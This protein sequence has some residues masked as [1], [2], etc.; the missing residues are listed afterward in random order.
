MRFPC[1]L[2]EFQAQFPNEAK[3]WSDLRE[4]RWPHGF[5]CPRCARRGSHFLATR[6]LEPCRTCR[7]QGSVTAGTAFH[8]TRVPLRIGFLGSF[9]LARHQKPPALFASP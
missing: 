1:T 3:C 4:A 5:R 2:L 7:Y 6:R 8:G 9:F